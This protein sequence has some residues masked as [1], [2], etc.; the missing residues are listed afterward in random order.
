MAYYD[1]LIAA[2]NNATQPPPGVTGAPLTQGMTTAQKVATVNAWKVAGPP[3]AM[4][5]P[6][7]KLYNCI[8]PAEW[9]ALTDPQRQNVRDILMLGQADGSPGTTVRTVLTTIFPQGTQTR[10]NLVALTAQ[11][12]TPE[13]IDWCYA[14]K[15][16]TYG[17][18]G[19][20]NLS[21]S[22]AANAGLT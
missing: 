19:P 10:A 18:P 22:D 14:N 2:W 16:P 4:V 9:N 1:A 12:D 21:T 7:Y 13:N 11:F 3:V 20:G 17:P 6:T 5:V 15:Y 8:V